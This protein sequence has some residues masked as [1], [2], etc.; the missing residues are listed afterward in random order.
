MIDNLVSDSFDSSELFT[1][2]ATK[3]YYS[4]N[5]R[6]NKSIISGYERSEGEIGGNV[7]QDG[8]LPNHSRNKSSF[9]RNNELNQTYGLDENRNIVDLDNEKPIYDSSDGPVAKG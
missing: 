8:T 5:L 3:S 6:M 7:N 1:E 9:I 2:E 4:N